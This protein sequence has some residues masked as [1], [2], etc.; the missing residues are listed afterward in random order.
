MLVLVAYAS[1]LGSTRDIAERIAARCVERGV[2]A[3][4]VP[5]NDVIAVAPYAAV[6]VGSAVHDQRWLPDGVQFLRDNRELLDARPVWLFSVG[7][8]A[9]LRLPARGL[10]RRE[11]DRIGAGLPQPA[12][13]QGHRLFS[14][15]SRPAQHYGIARLLYRLVGRYGDFRD[16]P[17]IDAWAGEIIATLRSET[18]QVRPAVSRR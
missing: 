5:V 14:G 15:V 1:A 12:R 11:R 18:R 6:I 10:A 2:H 7:M 3:H 17:A 4:V 8:P 13:C 9:A 16:W